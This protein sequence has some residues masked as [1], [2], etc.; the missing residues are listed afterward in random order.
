[1]EEIQPVTEAIMALGTGGVLT[2][3]FALL[4]MIS[5]LVWIVYK[6][7]GNHINHSTVVMTKLEGSVDKLTETLE[8]K[9]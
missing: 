7:A 4:A 6:L 8:R 3:I 9:L 1:M 2:L 5:G